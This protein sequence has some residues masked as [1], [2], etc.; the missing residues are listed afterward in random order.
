MKSVVLAL[1]LVLCASVSS[2]QIITEKVISWDI[3]VCAPGSNPA[4]CTSVLP[5][6]NVTL[7]AAQ[8]GLTRGTMPATVIVSAT[9]EL[10]VDD[11]ADTTKDCKL[12]TAGPTSF[13]FALQ[14]AAGYFAV[15]TSIGDKGTRVRG[16]GSNP[17]DRQV[18]QP[19]PGTG[20]RVK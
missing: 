14:P 16:A 11:P 13:L 5:A 19:L 12:N 18:V 10:Y 20:V 3:D 4:T 2:A 9:T 17:F 1:G 6:K 8:C 15:A 7:A